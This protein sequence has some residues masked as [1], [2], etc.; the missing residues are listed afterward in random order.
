M[1]P[2]FSSLQQCC[3]IGTFVLGYFIFAAANSLVLGLV[4]GLPLDVRVA[5]P[6]PAMARGFLRRGRGKST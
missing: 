2:L 1:Q 3:E 6:N 5:D 4:P